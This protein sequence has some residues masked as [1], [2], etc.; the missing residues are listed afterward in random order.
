[1]SGLVTADPDVV[2]D[3]SPSDDHEDD[4]NGSLSDSDA[5]LFAIAS[6]PPSTR[7][8]KAKDNI[9][10]VTLQEIAAMEKVPVCLL[11]ANEKGE[12]KFLVFQHVKSAAFRVDST[13]LR[14]TLLG[15]FHALFVRGGSLDL[16]TLLPVD[17]F[18]WSAWNQLK[19]RIMGEELSEFTEKVGKLFRLQLGH[20]ITGKKILCTKEQLKEVAVVSSQMQEKI[21]LNYPKM[22]NRSFDENKFLKAVDDLNRGIFRTPNPKSLEY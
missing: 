10:Q 9:E 7:M 3:D 8:L 6:S 22:V 13:F 16:N 2:L 1:M 4:G 21:L 20:G 18:L 5:E 15:N 12:T 19:K 11:L 17:C 14:I